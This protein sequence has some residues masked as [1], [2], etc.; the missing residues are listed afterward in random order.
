MRRPWAPLAAILV[1]LLVG[2][3]AL[4]SWA[5]Q[6]PPGPDLAAANDLVQITVTHWPQLSDAPYPADAPDFTVV[7][8]SGTVII[9]RGPAITDD[10]DATRHRAHALGVVVAEQRVA[11][12]YIADAP[13]AAETAQRAT[14]ARTGLALLGLVA[15]AV[16][17]WY[18]VIWR[19][20]LRPFTELDE[21]AAAVAS[22]DLDAPLRM[23]RANSFGAFTESFDLMRT[24]LARARAAEAD[25]QASKR[26]LIAQLSHD[27]RTPVASIGAAGEVLALNRDAAVAAKA[28][29][30]VDKSR[31]LESLVADLFNAND[32]Q[33]QALGV[34]PIELTSDKVVQ[35][36]R[37][38]DDYLAITKLDVPACLVSADPARLRQV[39]DN[40]LSNSA[41]YA[42]TPITINGQT[43]RQFLRL[44]IADAGPGVP[45]AELAGIVA[46]AVRGTNAGNQPG[47][48][49]GLFTSSQLMEKMG[50]GLEPE[51]LPDGFAV[52]VS[53]PLAGTI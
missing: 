45:D 11:T 43:D 42:A 26:D 14:I 36:L 48:G 19:R 4:L 9:H 35:L 28:Q 23:D 27:I 31:Q 25:A 38:A 2:A 32:D 3:G 20:L 24:E 46:K 41:K 33:L 51:N 8:T 53:I 34:N 16:T 30:I 15:L 6:P 7:D 18:W 50:G 44:T 37:Q 21:F 22:G 52:R 29:L 12:I 13:L 5:R 17:A 49:L 1:V 47:L 40:I 10:L 39:F